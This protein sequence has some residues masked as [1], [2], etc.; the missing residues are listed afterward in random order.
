MCDPGV[1]EAQ[2]ILQRCAQHHMHTWEQRCMHHY[3]VARALLCVQPQGN[4]RFW[5]ILDMLQESLIPVK[6]S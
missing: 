4:L 1:K 2:I 5:K 3:S 6:A